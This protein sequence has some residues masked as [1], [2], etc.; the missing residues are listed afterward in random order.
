MQF[1]YQI[2][3]VDDEKNIRDML[4]TH[5]QLLGYKTFTAE[6]GQQALE[7]MSGNKCDMLI[8]DIS[9]PVMGGEQLLREVRKDYP[10]T[11]CIMMTGYVRMENILSCMRHG[12]ETCIFKPFS[13]FNEMDEAV[14]SAA[15]HLEHW[16]AKL[17][18][19]LKMKP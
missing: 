13:D 4:S 3:I 9:M 1:K 10:M 7:I 16:E 14:K 2:L 19:I 5:F 6:N 17:G 18:M 11:H 15:A 12:A 8:S